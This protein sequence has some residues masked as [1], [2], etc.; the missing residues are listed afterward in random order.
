MYEKLIE[1]S[2]QH[3]SY[4]PW[5]K[6]RTLYTTLVSEI[7]LQQTTVS[8]VVN[9]FEAF[10]KK[11]PTIA[12]LARI[13]EEQI[14]K[15]WKGLGYYRR[16]RNLL[17]AAKIIQVDYQGEIPLSKEKLLSIKGIGEYTANAL[18]SIGENR[19]ALSV[20]AN[21]ERVLSRLYGLEELK[22]INLQKAI[23]K[24]F[25][26]GSICSGIDKYGPRVFNETLMDLGRSLCKART[27]NCELCSMNR[28]CKAFKSG[29]PLSFPKTKPE[30]SSKKFFKLNLLRVIVKSDES[31]LVYKKSEKEW[32]SNQY[33]VP[34]FI[35]GSEDQNL[36]Q[37]PQID[38]E[39]LDL[40]PSFKTSI[41]K[42]NIRNFILYASEDELLE[43]SKK[44]FVWKKIEALNLST[45]SLKSL[46][47]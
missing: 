33:E 32:L 18:L 14:L 26:E 6:Q 41:T 36:E 40:L 7:M 5:R 24:Y 2:T 22:G 16:A 37:Y 25:N 29:K 20:D 15:D 43:I 9:Y 21:L 34:T 17:A 27:V 13:D 45:S 31:L 8:T 28:H 35:L 47:Y 38:N 30:F 4:L 42:Y 12:S 3:Y 11:Y 10:I 44:E 1:W 19:R 39:H 46:L 23:Y